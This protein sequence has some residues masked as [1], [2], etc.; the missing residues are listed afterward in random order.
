MS[1]TQGATLQDTAAL[2]FKRIM[3]PMYPKDNI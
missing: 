1:M 2:P 3:R